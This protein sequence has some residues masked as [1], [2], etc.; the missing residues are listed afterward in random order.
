[1]LR[2]HLTPKGA[3]EIKKGLEFY[4]HLTPNGVKPG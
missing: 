1:M 3:H 2:E 4:K